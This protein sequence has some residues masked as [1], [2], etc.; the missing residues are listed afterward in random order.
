MIDESIVKNDSFHEE[1]GNSSRNSLDNSDNDSQ[2]NLKNK[3][4]KEEDE[5]ENQ[6]L[7]TY[8]NLIEIEEWLIAGF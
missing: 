7:R 6:N 4:Q 8:D 2:K 1:N 3:I 5:D